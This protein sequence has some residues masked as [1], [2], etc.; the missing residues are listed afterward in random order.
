MATN[1]A[2]RARDPRTGA[3]L[4][5][6]RE[7]ATPLEFAGFDSLRRQLALADTKHQVTLLDL[8]SGEARL[9]DT[10][11]AGR[12]GWFRSAAPPRTSAARRAWC[13]S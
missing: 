13:S 12:V 3:L 8:A 9:C 1:G 4:R 10:P 5:T 11:G 2:V 6:L 7:P